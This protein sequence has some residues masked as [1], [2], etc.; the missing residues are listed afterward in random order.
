MYILGVNYGHPDAGVT[1]VKDGRILVSCTEERFNR[2]K[3]YSDLP[4][5]SLSYCLKEGGVSID[6][7]DHIA[8]PSANLSDNKLKLVLKKQ[9]KGG[10]AFAQYAPDMSLVDY[11]RLFAL[12]IGKR[13]HGLVHEELPAYIKPYSSNSTPFSFVDHHTAHAASAYYTSG[14]SAKTLVIT[15]DGS[16]DLLSTTVWV[17]KDGVLTPRIKIGNKGSMGYFYGLVT[18][19]LG[20]WIGDGEGKT[21][22]LAP[23]GNFKKCKGILDKYLPKYKQ[24]KL[25]GGVDFGPVGAWKIPAGTIHWHFRDSKQIEKLIDKYGREN[26][27]A[28]AQRLLENEMIDFVSYWL[29][30]EK[31]R[32]LAVAGGV[33]LN[34]KLN[35]RLWQTGFLDNF[36]IYPDAGDGGLSA[37]ASLYSYFSKNDNKIIFPLKSVYFGPEFSNR[38]IESI[39]KTRKIKYKRLSTSEIIKKTAIVL[40]KNKIVGW[41]QGKMEAGPRALGNRSILMDPR[42]GRNKDIINKRVKYREKFRP[43]CPSM[44]P[45]ASKEFLVNPMPN[46][47]FMIVSFDIFSKKANKIPAVVHIDGTSRPQ[48]VS[49]EQNQLFFNLLKEFG[50]ISGVEVL[51]NTSFNIKGEPIVCTP[52]DALKC[53]IDTGLDYLVMGNFFISK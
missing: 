49:K 3:H 20:W 25:K 47:N 45:S 9:S 46:A 53:F 36:H 23:Y 31:V 27:A 26:I 11:L 29:K 37:G 13:V 38:K 21:M 48:I 22:G 39:L 18:E 50:K 7:I 19:A 16:G 32:N 28:E 44:T 42:F 52:A 43:F 33:F 4:F 1:L 34:V 5:L 2:I 40:A 14:F 6:D 51:L 30:N 10:L 12:F 35:Q 24:G 8:I 15:A 41:F 17:G